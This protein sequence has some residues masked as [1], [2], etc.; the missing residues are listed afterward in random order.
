MNIDFKGFGEQVATFIADENLGK[1]GVPVKIS[2]N[3]TVTACGASENFCGICVGLRDGYAAVQLKGFVNMAA[4]KNTGTGF[5][6]LCATA[7]GKITSATTGR[8][9]LVVT[10]D[11]SNV[12]FI[13]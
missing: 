12:G 6:K 13:L 4:A 2:A 1:T 9:C 10:A 11:D 8:E 5:Q 3:G 7:D